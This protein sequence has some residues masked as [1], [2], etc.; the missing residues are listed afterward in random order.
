MATDKGRLLGQPW[1]WRTQ[2][3]RSET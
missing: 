1:R 2:W 3:V